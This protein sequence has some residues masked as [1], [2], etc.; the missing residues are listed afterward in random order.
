MFWNL[1]NVAQFDS[2]NRLWM[3]VSKIQMCKTALPFRNFRHGVWVGSSLSV[4]HTLGK[5]QGKAWTDEQYRETG[6][7]REVSQKK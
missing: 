1:S 5:L 4:F 6:W 2:G 7:V 3:R